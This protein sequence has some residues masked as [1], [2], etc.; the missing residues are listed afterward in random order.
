M[1]CSNSSLP[2]TSNDTAER[3]ASCGC[4]DNFQAA[5]RGSLPN[6]G[7]DPVWQ[8]SNTH[9]LVNTTCWDEI[10]EGAG[11]PT[12]PGHREWVDCLFY[13]SSS[14]AAPQP[15]QVVT[16]DP[17]SISVVVGEPGQHAIALPVPEGIRPII[18][19]AIMSL[20]PTIP[21]G[22]YYIIGPTATYFYAQQGA[23]TL[24]DVV[25]Q[26]RSAPTVNREFNISLRISWGGFVCRTK[27]CGRQVAGQT[28]ALQLWQ[29]DDGEGYLLSYARLKMLC[30]FAVQTLPQA[31]NRTNDTAHDRWPNTVFAVAVC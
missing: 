1:I 30:C 22:W 28:V 2:T 15:I 31:C 20:D 16:G 4:G 21:A 14:D 9:L 17:V 10:M 27:W 7:R 13:N 5:H 8:L 25:F 29:A 12:K 23:G 18:G 19:Y 3:G 6:N 11:N 26:P 24:R